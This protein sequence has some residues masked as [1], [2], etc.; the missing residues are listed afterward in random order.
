M[1]KPVWLSLILDKLFLNAFRL[2]ASTVRWSS[3]F[4][5]WPPYSKKMPSALSFPKFQAVI[6]WLLCWHLLFGVTNICATGMHS[7]FEKTVFCG[8]GLEDTGLRLRFGL[9]ASVFDT[10]LM[11]VMFL[12][13]VAPLSGAEADV[14]AGARSRHSGQPIWCDPRSCHRC[15]GF[16]WGTVQWI[17]SRS[18]RICWGSCWWIQEFVQQYCR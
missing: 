7:R 17:N 2:G 4:I 18:G 14:Q 9:A 1:K 11:S 12:W 13:H 6:H 16:L 8:L 10:G 15:P 5:Y 3:R